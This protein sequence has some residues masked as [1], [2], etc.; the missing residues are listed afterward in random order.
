[1]NDQVVIFAGTGV[2]TFL[3]ALFAYRRIGRSSTVNLSETG[4]LSLTF[5][6]AHHAFDLSSDNTEVEMVDF[7]GDAGWSVRLLRRG[8][9]PIE[10]DTSSVDPVLFTEALR[11]WRPQL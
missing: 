5:G 8:L 10:V 6:D 3:A 9:P 1:M 2:L 7:P 4:V 11:Q